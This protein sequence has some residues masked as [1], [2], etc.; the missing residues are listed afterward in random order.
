[1]PIERETENGKVKTGRKNKKA[2]L[3]RKKEQ[4]L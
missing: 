4:S 2:R 1:M 3:L